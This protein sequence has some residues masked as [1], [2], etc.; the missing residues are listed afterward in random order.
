M[1]HKHFPTLLS[2]VCLAVGLFAASPTVLLAQVKTDGIPTRDQVGAL[3]L[4]ADIAPIEAPFDM[5]RLTRPQ[6]KA[7]TLSIT[8][9]GAKEGKMA[10]RAIQKAIDRM[11]RQGGGTVLVPAGV[12]NTGRI[13]LKSDVNLHLAEGAELHF[14]G[15]I[16]DYQ[17]AVF[18]RNEGVE[19]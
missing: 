6:F 17:P 3:N 5:P 16:K 9:T 10:T 7:D 14:S 2:T 15:N 1:N 4:P 11:N 12:W 19:L 8:Q 18:T 13:E